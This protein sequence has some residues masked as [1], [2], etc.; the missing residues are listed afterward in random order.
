MNEARERETDRWA[1]E[2]KTGT[3]LRPGEEVLEDAEITDDP[4][5][6]KEPPIDI[7]GPWR[8]AYHYHCWWVVGHH[9]MHPCRD[10]REA[11]K[12]CGRLKDDWKET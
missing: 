2:E 11:E 9:M 3:I 12:L 4:S 1:G 6:V 5:F 7:R 10:E 8:K